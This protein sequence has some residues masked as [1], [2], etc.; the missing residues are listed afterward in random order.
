MTAEQHLMM[1]TAAKDF[2][3][4]NALAEI[5][6]LNALLPKPEAQKPEPEGQS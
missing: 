2:Q 3:L 1:L 5:D 4:A 6:R